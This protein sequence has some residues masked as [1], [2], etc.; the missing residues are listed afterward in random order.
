MPTQPKIGFT[1]TVLYRQIPEL[2]FNLD[3]YLTHHIPL[4]LRLW[5][6]HGVIDCR[7]VEASPD[8]E[9]AYVVTMMWENES[10][11]QKA[12]AHKEAMAEIMGDVGNFTNGK[13]LFVVGRVVYG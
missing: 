3:H 2:K 12:F 4:C 5:K 6:P 1:S 9:Y 13:P 7:V 10:Q 11:Y 8:Q